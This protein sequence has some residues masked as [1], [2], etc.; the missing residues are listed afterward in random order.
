MLSYSVNLASENDICWISDC[1]RN[2]YEDNDVIPLEVLL[3]W[4]DRNPNGFYVVKD[5]SGANVG[6]I[7]ILPIKQKTLEDLLIGKIC[8][9]EIRG[10]S[11]YS[12]QERGLVKFLYVENIMFSSLPAVSK[13][14]A[15]CTLFLQLPQIVEN[16]CEPNNLEKIYCIA[17]TKAGKK[18]VE[19]L[20]FTISQKGSNRKD[21]H[22]LYSVQ[23]ENLYFKVASLCE[24]VL[25]RSIK[26]S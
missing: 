23:Y 11:L 2:I 13:M 22:D 7:D 16:L 9:F 19:R 24:R 25:N 17:A 15:V 26:V 4:Y 10:D 14:I 5:S 1:E 21:G 6:N 3:A 18:L 12:P 8:E 20:S